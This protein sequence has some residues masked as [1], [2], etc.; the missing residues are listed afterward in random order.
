MA[1]HSFDVELAT[2]RVVAAAST[3][4]GGGGGGG[5]KTSTEASKHLKRQRT[6]LLLTTAHGPPPAARPTSALISET[7]V[8]LKLLELFHQWDIDGNNVL[9]VP[10][11]V[12]GLHLA[13]VRA[14][15]TL[16]TRM[17][18]EVSMETS[19]HGKFTTDL[20]TL[21]NDEFVRLMRRPEMLG[22]RPH[23]EQMAAID[24]MRRGILQTGIKDHI[25]RLRKRAAAKLETAPG[26]A[27]GMSAL[28]ERKTP[29][30]PRHSIRE[31]SIEQLYSFKDVER[32]LES[33]TCCG[34]RVPCNTFW[35]WFR[36]SPKAQLVFLFLVWWMAG[37][38]I[39][40]GV[41]GWPFVNAF[42]Y[43]I[44]AG[45]SIG[46]G[47]LSETVAGGW[48]RFEL[49]VD[50]DDTH[51]VAPNATRLFTR[52]MATDEPYR[53]AISDH[54]NVPR[55]HL[56]A[57]LYAD[58]PGQLLS[59]SYTIVHICLG[60]VLISAIL[61]IVA[62]NSIEQ[63]E[64]WYNEEKDHDQLKEMRAK[65]RGQ[66]LRL[67]WGRTKIWM[68]D[69]WDL[70]MAWGLLVS[71]VLAGA[72][73][74]A[75]LENT[76]YHV[77]LY[78]A[79]SAASTAGLLGPSPNNQESLVF[80]MF[81]SLVGVPL[82]ANGLGELSSALT[83]GYI[84]DKAED[85]RYA[86]V[87][88][89][90]Y[91]YMC[92]L[93]DQDGKIDKFEFAMLWCLRNGLCEPSHLK[94]LI[95]DF[96]DLDV[97]GNGIFSKSEMQAS[98]AFEASDRNHDGHLSAEECVDIARKL[99]SLPATEFPGKFLL[100]PEQQY[101]V[102]RV[103]ASL[104]Q[105][106][107][108]PIKVFKKRAK[109]RTATALRKKSS[110]RREKMVTQTKTVQAEILSLNRR[111]FMRW[112]WSEFKEYT[113]DAEQSVLSEG[114]IQIQMLLA[115][116]SEDEEQQRTAGGGCAGVDEAGVVLTAIEGKQTEE[117]EHAETESS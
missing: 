74:F 103:R 88:D 48:N 108:N 53:N 75:A 82:Y 107:A 25:A 2:P 102:E 15:P 21:S 5:C 43:A 30:V 3:C 8:R 110:F 54:A 111:E 73:I 99:Q 44:Q 37:A 65:Y 67:V 79:V 104:R 18:F 84:R 45:F 7:E 40:V 114:T 38:G 35:Q 98:C 97:D 116:I 52:L 24:A 106:D 78:F 19:Q 68:G 34:W 101:T 4:G 56:C 71:W 6:T 16:L 62:M 49:C 113:R 83:A 10:E 32:Y 17:I 33:V 27:D 100:D 22:G 86:G 13:G 92:R 46:Y 61:S 20:T 69:H 72:G 115:A 39:Y 95:D 91:N 14:D 105:F 58:N 51:G 80:V 112:W 94:E 117:E 77:G 12:L 31:S 63:S 9:A 70:M 89:N 41:D 81:Y 50:G 26:S 66:P 57:Y 90:E 87:T 11:V 109:M 76:D 59:M 55:A 1:A 60:A 93:G 28:T 47:S 23:N 29:P 36:D 85:K 42:Y 64:K 96:E